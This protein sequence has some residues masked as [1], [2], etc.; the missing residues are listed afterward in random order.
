M[1]PELFN[2]IIVGPA[3][4][5][6]DPRYDTPEARAMLIAIALQES[7]LK[8]R[9]QS[10]DGPARSFWQFE[11]GGVSGVAYHKVTAPILSKVCDELEYKTDVDLIY[12]AIEHNDLLAAVC[13]RLLLFTHPDPIPPESEWMK[14][15]EIYAHD[16]WKPGK[17]RFETWERNWKAAWSI[18]N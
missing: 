1:N 9:T 7:G 15:W 16:L 5:L 12:A 8:A 18:L 14:G 11:R 10:G 2:R 3:L 4:S 13:A 17:P 6:L